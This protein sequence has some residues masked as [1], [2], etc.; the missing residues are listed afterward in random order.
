MIYLMRHGQTDWNVL[1]KIQGRT[2]IALNEEGRQMAKEARTKYADISFDVCYC[3][4]L[5]RAKETAEIFL[6]GRDT[7]I[8]FDDRLMEMSFG[9]CEGEEHVLENP[10]SPLYPLFT[11]P[12]HYTAVEGAES[13]DELF[14]RSGAFIDE[15]LLPAVSKGRN[16]LIVSHGAVGCSIIC[17]L[18]QIER[19]DFWNVLCKNCELV[20]IL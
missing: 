7:P 2:D 16:I 13:L 15:M 20:R 12:V 18:K 8:I 11:D 17:R 9:I 14:A 6:E 5:V 4:P 10:S 1:R 3:S 19:S